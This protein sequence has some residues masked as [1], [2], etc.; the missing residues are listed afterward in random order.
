MTEIYLSGRTQLGL[1]EFEYSFESN[2]SKRIAVVGPNGSGKTTL[3]RLIAGHNRLHSGLLKIGGYVYDEPAS[4]NF[5]PAHRRKVTLQH[6]GG[7][8]FPHL[9]V[10]DNVAFP[11]RSKRNS[12]RKAR[13][14]ASETLEAFDLLQ[15][16]DKYPNQL[17]G[18]QVGRVSLARSLAKQPRLL[19]LDEP[20]SALDVESV[21]QVHQ[22]LQSLTTTLLLVSHDP[23]EVL[24]LSDSIIA[25]EENKIIQFG[26]LESV[27][28]RPATQWLSKF[29]DLNLVSG[30]ASGL[31]FKT[32]S[33]EIL[34]LSQSHSGNVEVSFPSSA[35]SLHLSP[36][37]GSP[38]NKWKATVTSLDTKDNLVRVK[39]VGT[40][41]CYATI[42]VPSFNELEIA[43][44]STIWASIKATE[45]NV[46]QN[47][48]P[49]KT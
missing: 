25:L 1:E 5:T 15:I 38:R 6:Q 39:L 9:T 45:L 24:K 12:K 19:M 2:S 31:E 48:I 37:T 18:G 21:G 43:L 40:F 28:S 29:F 49:A 35:V 16:K 10:E 4:E 20:T 11:Y 34:Q 17:S 36:P 32:D 14:L 27:I 30:T 44:G 3:L 47:P 22:I 41:D 33:G 46:L 8:I 13:T 23:I 7:S 26:A 42:T